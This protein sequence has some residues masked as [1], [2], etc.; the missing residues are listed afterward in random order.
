MKMCVLDVQKDISVT[1][2]FLYDFMLFAQYLLVFRV[3]SLYMIGYSYKCVWQNRLNEDIKK[4]LCASI[5]NILG[6]ILSKFS[7]N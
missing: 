5:W 1:N 2:F 6:H 3:L 7:E 4:I